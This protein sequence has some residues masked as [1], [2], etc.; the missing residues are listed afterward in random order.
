MV[1]DAPATQPTSHY[2]TDRLISE[3]I[4]F[5]YGAEYFGVPNFPRTLA[6]LAIAV[7]GDRPARKALDLGCA[8]GR[9]T[10]A[11]VAGFAAGRV[12]GSGRRGC[13]ARFDVDRLQAF[14]AVW[15]PGLTS[16]D[17]SGCSRS[18]S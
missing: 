1:A 7:M 15:R 3:Y 14:V 16:R 10:E 8:T 4:E 5:H 13:P 17:F 9:A 12:G 11:A 2:E 6:Q 18:S